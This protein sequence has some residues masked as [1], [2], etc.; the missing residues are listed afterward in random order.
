MF[1]SMFTG[2]SEGFM[3][4]RNLSNSYSE[5][6][7]GITTQVEKSKKMTIVNFMDYKN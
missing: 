4:D 1:S 3:A 2:E 7:Y 6:R 5:V